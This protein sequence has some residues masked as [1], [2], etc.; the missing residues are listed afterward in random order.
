MPRPITPILILGL[1]AACTRPQDPPGP[2]EVAGQL[3]IGG[4]AGVLAAAAMTGKLR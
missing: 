3:I 4:A 2:G 1:L